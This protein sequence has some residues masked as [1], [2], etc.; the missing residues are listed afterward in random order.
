MRAGRMTPGQQRGW[1]EGF[2]QYGL[3]AEQGALD[4][5]DQFGASGRRIVEIG[6]GMGD[7]LIQMAQADP[8]AQFIGIEVHRPGV[9]RL[10]SRVL[11]EKIQNVRVY[12]EDAVDV[13]AQSLALESLDAI[14]IFFPDPWHKKRHHKRRLIQPGWV[15]EITQRLK[16]GGYLH[17]ATDWEPYAEHM[18]DVLEDVPSLKNASGAP[19]SAVP[20][21]DYRPL[22]KF[23]ARGER[24]G[25]RVQDLVY[26]KEPL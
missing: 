6:F 13:F 14:H 9:G 16:A 23:E 11:A 15:R 17:L 7:S 10:L 25:H 12:A 20:R 3:S 2:P 4:W 22:T 19:R 26:L 1:D 8:G 24:L 21:P 5:D 18:F